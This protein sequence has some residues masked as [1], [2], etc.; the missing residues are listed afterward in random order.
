MPI[1]TRIRNGSPVRFFEVMEY[2][3]YQTGGR[4]WLG[5]RSL[6]AGEV[7]PQPVLGPLRA[8]TGFALRY[9]DR[10]NQIINP[11]DA[12]RYRDIRVIEITLRGE[13]NSAVSRTDR[14]AL[15][16]KADSLVT[17]VALRNALRP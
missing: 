3:L 8:G 10:D 16:I 2:S 4:S 6:T 14:G 13:T 15:A 1:G 17:R 12:G 5:A 9:F 7:A 11:G